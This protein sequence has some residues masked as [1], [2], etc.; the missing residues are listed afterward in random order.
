MQRWK[1]KKEVI[2]MLGESMN[3]PKMQTADETMIAVVHLLNS[4][5][6]GCDD[7]DMRIHQSGLHNMISQRGGL[8]SLGV[9]GQ[10]ASILT[11]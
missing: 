8:N 7:R 11:G 9:G 6:M 3:D 1:V 4:D 10:L 5:I 2:A